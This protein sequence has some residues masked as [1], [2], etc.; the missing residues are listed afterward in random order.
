M[1]ARV[2]ALA[3]ARGVPPWSGRFEVRDGPAATGGGPT[4]RMWTIAAAG[5]ASA[6]ATVIFMPGTNAY[7]L[8]YGE[9][10][11]RLA[12]AGYRVIG[13][14]PRG[15]GL[16]EGARGS[17]TGGELI[18]ELAA[19]GAWARER[20]GDPVFVGGSS[21]GGIAAFYCAAR[22]P[23]LAGAI[24]HNLADL[25]APESSARLTRFGRAGALLKPVL[26]R[27]A[28]LLPELRVP[29]A[30][31][32]DLRK[33]PVRGLGSARDVIRADPF[34]PDFVRLKTLASLASE[35]LARPVEAIEVPV[36][37]LHA[38]A[39]TIF[40]ADYIEG[41]FRRLPDGK[42]HR[43]RVYEGRAHYFIVDH[44]EEVARDVDAWLTDTLARGRSGP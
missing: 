28:R 8:L 7:A 20:H 38:G 17:Y 35:T 30:A 14:D 9:F 3:R 32:L 26:V 41:V 27:A 13:L 4:L 23:A 36:L 39:D 16:S 6:R 2:D 1:R 15:H 12:D 43:L 21:Q 37:A 29:M 10:L 40:P 34:V 31:Y 33:E 42:G 11:T 24:C 18:D 44:A 22:D 19:V 5:G 25:S